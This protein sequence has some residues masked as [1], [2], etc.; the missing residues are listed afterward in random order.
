MVKWIAIVFVTVCLS[1]ES[2]FILLQGYVLLIYP[3]QKACWSWGLNTIR[4]GNCPSRKIEQTTQ[5]SIRFISFK[6]I[7]VFNLAI[8]TSTS[9]LVHIWVGFHQSKHCI[10]NVNNRMKWLWSNVTWISLSFL[11]STLK[12][13]SCYN[14]IIVRLVMTAC[15]HI[16]LFV[17]YYHHAHSHHSKGGTPHSPHHHASTPGIPGAMMGGASSPSHSVATTRGSYH[18]PPTPTGHVPAHIGKSKRWDLTHCRRQ[19]LDGILSV[20]FIEWYAIMCNRYPRMTPY[21]ITYY[22]SF[23]LK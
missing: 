11:L 14:L 13:W 15:A 7:L 20:V 19:I 1:V 21:G 4:L 18:K 5:S 3:R 16:N 6:D 17:E 2:S 22:V 12:L 10:N 8:R 23:Q 9:N